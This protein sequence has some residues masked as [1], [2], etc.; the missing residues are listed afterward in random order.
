MPISVGSI[1]LFVSSLLIV[2][3]GVGRFNSAC[4]NSFFLGVVVSRY[5]Y[6][7]F[8]MMEMETIN[9]R[10]TKKMLFGISLVT[11]VIGCSTLYCLDY[12]CDFVT[13]EPISEWYIFVKP[14]LLAIVGVSTYGL[15]KGALDKFYLSKHARVVDRCWLSFLDKYSYDIYLTHYPLLLSASMCIMNITH[16]TVINLILLIAVSIV[17][18][19]GIGEVSR[20][21]RD[22]ILDFAINLH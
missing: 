7:P 5:R 20:V 13:R 14:Y 21:I 1:L 15:L 11:N 8:R 10:K 18:A 16:I 6:S 9:N 17:L 22:R 4:L 12:L 2:I 19:V 3:I